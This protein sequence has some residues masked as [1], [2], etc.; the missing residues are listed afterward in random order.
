VDAEK[1]YT[2]LAH[3]RQTYDMHGMCSLANFDLNVF[4]AGWIELE[5]FQV[6]STLMLDEKLKP[7]QIDSRIRSERE[8]TRKKIA[9]EERIRHTSCTG[10]KVFQ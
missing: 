4:H 6:S 10:F 8:K 2:K 5:N 9:F 3:G 7:Y 1:R